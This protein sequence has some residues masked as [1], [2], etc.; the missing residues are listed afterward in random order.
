MSTTG[1]RY[2]V[3]SF[4]VTIAGFDDPTACKAFA[5]QLAGKNRRSPR[6]APVAIDTQTGQ[7]IP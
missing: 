1:H 7:P 6:F 2:E 5:S 3:Q 4:G